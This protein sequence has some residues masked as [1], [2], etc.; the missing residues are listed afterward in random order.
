MKTFKLIYLLSIFIFL[1]A[2]EP[3]EYRG[4]EVGIWTEAVY[5]IL[6]VEGLGTDGVEVIEVDNYGRKLYSFNDSVNF[7]G[8]G[9]YILISQMEDNEYIYYY[10]NFN[11]LPIIDRYYSETKVYEL[12]ESNDWNKDMN[13]SKCIKQRKKREKKKSQ[14]NDSVIKTVFKTL[15]GIDTDYFPRL[16]DIDF[17]NKHLFCLTEYG[18]GYTNIETYVIIIK[19]DGSYENENSLIKIDDIYNYNEQL[20]EF[21]RLNNWK[22]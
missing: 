13:I 19:L 9:N 3:R 5:S 11:F 20:A 18:G 17:E 21:K 22:I 10:D 1:V 8:I 4:D 7:N 6:G 14:I 16:Y 2:C 12:K 15:S